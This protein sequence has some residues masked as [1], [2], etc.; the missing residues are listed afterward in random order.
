[1]ERENDFEVQQQKLREAI[2]EGASREISAFIANYQQRVHIFAEEYTY[3]LEQ[4]AHRP[5]D[6]KLINS[7]EIRLKQRFPNY[8]NYALTTPEGISIVDRFEMEIGELCRNDLRHFSHGMNANVAGS[9]N[10]VSIHPRAGDYHFDVMSG[11]RGQQSTGIFLVSYPATV[12]GNMLASYELPGHQLLLV[13][14]DKRGLIEIAA[15]GGRDTLQRDANLSPTEIPQLPSGK[16]IKGSRWALID[17]ID[18]Q[19]I[20]SHHRELRIQ[21]LLVLLTVIAGTILILAVTRR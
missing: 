13:H 8:S 6:E 17:L 4:L 15:T 20:S 3:L 1:M 19:M 10:D 12:I 11:W 18:P 16:N 9:F 21:A 5:R 7:L 14:R 2:T